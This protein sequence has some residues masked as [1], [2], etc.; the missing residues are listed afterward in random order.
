MSSVFSSAIIVFQEENRLKK[1]YGKENCMVRTPKTTRRSG[2]FHEMEV[3]TS[4]CGRTPV[5]SSTQCLYYPDSAIVESLSFFSCS[6]DY[7]VRHLHQE[8][9]RNKS[10]LC[11]NL[12]CARANI[13]NKHACSHR[14]YKYR[15]RAVH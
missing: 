8:Q 7:R 10:S 5:S 14:V 2:Q 9:N 11:S 3:F 13:S 12:K 6:V 4:A 1:V 15:S